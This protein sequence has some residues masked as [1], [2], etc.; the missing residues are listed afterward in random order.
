MSKLRVY[1]AGPIANRTYDDA[2]NWRMN[3]F[4]LLYAHDI[5]ALDPMRAKGALRN[6]VIGQDFNA[7]QH[8]GQ[9]YTARGIT[10]RDRSD[11]MRS[12]ALLVNL[13]GEDIS[14]GTMIEL[15]WADAY[16]KPV[17]A[18][19]REGN[20]Y[21]GHPMVHGIIGY[22]AKDL[23]EAVEAIAWILNR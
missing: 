7:Y 15:G 17:V 6:T 1:L 13:L 23:D 5:E 12:D 8:Y 2:I 11:V 16:R 19:I 22:K 21:D 18:M 20:R 14:A 3:A 4:N 9:F 10:T